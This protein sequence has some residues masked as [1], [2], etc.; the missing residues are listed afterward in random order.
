MTYADDPEGFMAAKEELRKAIVAF[1]ANVEP[2]TFL[3]DWVLVVH[4]DSVQLSQQMS[5][6]V[7]YLVPLDQ[8]YHRTTGL[9]THALEYAKQI[10]N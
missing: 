4:K 7:A 6:E 8:P 10:E 1:Y 5:S 3:D 2:D 9:L